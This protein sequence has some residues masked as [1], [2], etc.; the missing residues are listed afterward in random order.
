MDERPSPRSIMQ[1]DRPLTDAEREFVA[2]CAVVVAPLFD[3]FGWTWA[4]GDGGAAVPTAE[5]IAET[6]AWLIGRGG[7]STG[8]IVV[9]RGVDGEVGGEQWRMLLD[10]GSLWA[11]GEVHVEDTPARF[12]PAAGGRPEGNEGAAGG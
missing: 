6:I 3:R 5:G 11:D 4:T 8:R 10:I 2:R 9:G 7:G 12:A 1:P